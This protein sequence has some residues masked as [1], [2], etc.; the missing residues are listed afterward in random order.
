MVI[1][2]SYVSL[3]EGIPIFWRRP[4]S[5]TW[6]LQATVFVLK[7]PRDGWC[8][9]VPRDG[10]FSNLSQLQT[11]PK[12]QDHSCLQHHFWRL[13]KGK[14]DWRWITPLYPTVITIFTVSS[15]FADHCRPW[16]PFCSTA[17]ALASRTEMLLVIATAS[18]STSSQKIWTSHIARRSSQDGAPQIQQLD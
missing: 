2:H 1:F 13:E 14:M 7:V 18:R 11:V 16:F 8:D 10:F 6:F 4:T 12:V 15:S 5:A 9:N 17:G 3:P